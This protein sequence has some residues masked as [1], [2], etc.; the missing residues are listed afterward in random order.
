MRHGEIYFV[1]PNKN[2]TFA[3]DFRSEI[4]KRLCSQ[5]VNGNVRNFQKASERNSHAVCVVCYDYIFLQG[6]SHDLH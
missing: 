1:N 2:R 4:T 6:I 5:L 3:V